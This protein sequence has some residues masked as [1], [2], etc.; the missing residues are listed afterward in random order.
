MPAKNFLSK[1][2]KEKLL[3]T[4]RESDNPY[5]RRKCRSILSTVI[6]PE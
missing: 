2:Q 5:I 4:L 1:E 6:K 3:K